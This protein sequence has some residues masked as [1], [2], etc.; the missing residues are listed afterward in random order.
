MTIRIFR[1]LIYF[2]ILVIP[3]HIA[4]Y[5]FSILSIPVS[6]SIAFI[7]SSFAAML[8]DIWGVLNSIN[9]KL[10]QND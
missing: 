3:V 10:N 6:F 9:D 7:L 1:Q 8:N 2:V 5:H 4:L